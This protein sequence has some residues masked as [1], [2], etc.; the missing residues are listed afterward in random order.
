[1]RGRHGTRTPHPG[2]RPPHASWMSAKM[3][4]SVSLNHAALAP[5]PSAMPSFEP[6]HTGYMAQYEYDAAT[7]EVAVVAVRHQGRPVAQPPPARLTG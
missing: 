4:P 6:R 5:P 3:L 7:D 1:M 2:V